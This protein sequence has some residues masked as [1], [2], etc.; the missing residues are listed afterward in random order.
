MFLSN[1]SIRRPIAMSCLII[2]LAALGFNSYRKL[3]LELLPSVDIPYVTVVTTYPG[4]SPSEIE[5]DVAKPIEDAVVT[6][7]GLKHVTSSCMEDACQTMIEFNLDV[8]V[9][10]AATDVRDKIDLIINDFPEGVEKPKVLKYDINAQPVISLALTGDATVEELYDFADNTLSDRISTLSG[11]AE[12]QLV[13]GSEREV[14]V[15]LDRQRLAERGLTTMNIVQAIQGGVRTI[16]SGRVREDG[17]EYNVKFDADYSAV[18]D[19]GNLEIPTQSASRCYIKDLGDVIMT[20]EEQRQLSYV[21]GRPC[22]A[23][24]VVKKADA[25]AVEVVNR[26]RKAMDKLRAELPGGME[27][28]WVTDDGAFIKA[29]VDGTTSN[30]IQGILLTAA[31]LFFFLYN[32]RST[33]IVAL[34]MPLTIIIGILGMSAMGYTLNVSTLLAIGL[35]VGVLVTNS[36]VVLESIIKRFHAGESALEASREGASEVGVAVSASALTNLVVLI[37]VALM[38]SLVGSFFTPFALT[39]I[40]VTV[41]SLFISFTLTPILA[42]KMLKRSGKIGI[43]TW[44]EQRW[45]TFFDG[46]TRV[47]ERMLRFLA[48]HRW[49][50]GSVLLLSLIMLFHAFHIAGTLGFS[51]FS[52]SDRGE[53]M[54]KLEFPTGYDLNHTRERVLEMEKAVKDLPGL[55][56]IL[57]NIGKVEG[58][59]GQSSE[60]V[61]LAQLLLKFN[62]KNERPLGIWELQDEV[63]KRFAPFP[64]CI[65]AAQIKSAAGGQEAPIQFQVSGDDITQLEQIALK[66][67]ELAGAIPGIVTPDTTVRQGKP[68][69]RIHPSRPVLSDMNVVATDMGYMLRANLEGL[70]AGV[71]KQGA[72]TYD[73]RVKLKEE[74][75][76]AQVPEFLFPGA[77][78][79]PLLLSNVASIENRIA[80]VQITRNDKQRVARV[81]A[82]LEQS[83][84]LGTA[85]QKLSKEVDEKAGLPSGYSYRFVGDYEMMSD[86]AADF[87]EAGLIAI[88]LTYLVLAAILESFTQPFLILV[89]LPLG[90][91]GVFYSLYITG[92][93][94]SMFVLLGCVMLI[95]IVVNNAILIIDEVNQQ[96]RSGVN[97]RNAMIHAAADQFRPVVMITLAAVLGMLPLATSNGLGSEM[98]TGIGIASVGGIAVSALLTLLVIPVLYGV[99][100]RDPDKDKKKEEP[101][102]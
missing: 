66:S 81:Y 86:A 4:A 6:I 55:Q 78:G 41:A 56:H 36:I 21:D 42:S 53:M 85:V 67:A 91:I 25:N 39:T 27:L 68:E 72:R 43:L 60:G 92:E 88:V 24:S 94:I 15:E 61:Y 101:K 18:A 79:R 35:S 82:N 28:L 98:Q 83:L 52:E 58:A 29:S 46:I 63:R 14:H 40:F 23:I 77:P 5:T 19:M 8:N 71:F 89:T 59:V 90:M 10:V 17:S 11:V 96:V 62:D 16:P 84:P 7:D 54:V 73:I 37:P 44:M 49:A 87:A 13:G 9:D 93:S 20:T 75:G 99:F 26:V 1:A 65:V 102:A 32:L 74:E 34:T 80:P 51:F 31:I 22:I 95:G 70:K 64:D 47:Y 30:I 100:T 48:R 33:F 57:T 69:L 97:P 45:N 38:S 2:A 50:A 3:G 12:V 76:K